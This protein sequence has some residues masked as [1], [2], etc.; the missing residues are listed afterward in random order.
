MFKHLR[1]LICL[2]SVALF[3]PLAAWAQ[4]WAPGDADKK[5]SEAVVAAY[6]GALDAGK[7]EEAYALFTPALKAMAPF[8][9]WEKF[10]KLQ[11]EALGKNPQYK[12][13]QA[14]WS[15]NPPQAPPGVYVAY[16]L[17]AQFDKVRKCIELVVLQRQEDGAF[18]VV[19]HERTVLDG[20]N[21]ADIENKMSK[22]EGV[23]S[24]TTKPA[25]QTVE[26]TLAELRRRKDVTIAG[27]E[28]WTV[29]TADKDKAVWSF[30]QAG[31]AAHPAYAKRWPVV[32]GGKT[33]LKM[34]IVC[35]AAQPACDRL[36]ADFEALNR[37]TI[38]KSKP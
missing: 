25:R 9:E 34:E 24:V 29:A 2:L 35:E 1:L 23:E 30:T 26:A 13:A 11:N 28:G 12:S 19:R 32:E 14:D 8:R 3:V 17:E 36:A 37:Q 10:Q 33:V 6:L 5:R 20:K 38:A 27:H 7:M 15:V 16:T 31:H 4:E 21:A 18:R 22:I